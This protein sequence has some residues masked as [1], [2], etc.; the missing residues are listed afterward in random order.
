MRARSKR[1]FSAKEWCLNTLD[2]FLDRKEI[3]AVNP[4][5]NQAPVFIGRADAKA[6]ILWPPDVKEQ[7][8]QKDPDAGKD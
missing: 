8:I 4:K 1:K 5:D 6:P 3:K 2:S 7:L